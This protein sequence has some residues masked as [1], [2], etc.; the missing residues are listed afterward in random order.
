VSCSRHGAV[1]AACAACDGSAA[2]VSVSAHQCCTRQCG[3]A[4]CTRLPHAFCAATCMASN[5]VRHW[6]GKRAAQQFGLAPGGRRTPCSW[7][8][9]FLRA[10]GAAWHQAG[11]GAA[12]APAAARR[13]ARARP[14][15]AP[16]RTAP[17]PACR[18]P[19]A[20]GSKR[21]R[22]WSQGAGRAPWSALHLDKG[23]ARLQPAGAA[24]R[25]IMG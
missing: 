3:D 10:S 6:S 15:R 12:R 16:A 1:G 24:C 19:H 5:L 9:R 17:P 2:R 8:R 13:R 20:Q 14:A 18:R 4:Q 25:A 11:E 22:V 21:V 7:A 23:H